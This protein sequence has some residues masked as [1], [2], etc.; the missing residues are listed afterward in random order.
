MVTGVP[1]LKSGISA[2]ST[3]L[4]T[5]THPF[6]RFAPMVAGWLVPWMAMRPSPVPKCI[7]TSEWPE[8]PKANGP[9]G[10]GDGGGGR[11]GGG[12]GWED[13]P[14]EEL[15]GGGRRRRGAD[16][17]DGGEHHRVVGGADQLQ[18]VRGR[19][20]FNPVGG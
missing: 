9:Y 11:G 20:H 19:R 8:S 6:E 18:L 1:K 13:G 7:S 15:S 2:R 16:A 14:N 12:V 5:C 17:D 10:W 3:S 4:G